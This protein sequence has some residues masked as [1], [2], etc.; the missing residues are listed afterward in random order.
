[1]FSQ[2]CS[3]K[4]IH[5]HFHDYT[6]PHQWS[7][8]YILFQV[9]LPNIISNLSVIHGILYV[10]LFLALNGNTVLWFW[11]LLKFLRDLVGSK[12]NG[13]WLKI[14]CVTVFIVGKLVEMWVRGMQTGIKSSNKFSSAS[15]LATYP[16]TVW[17][18]QT[19]CGLK[20]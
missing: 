8:N 11:D 20:L 7:E 2:L 4:Q 16:V 6:Q 12:I 3:A 5:F 17:H 9:T 14:S 13:K 19:P 1:M 10:I 18:Y 15:L